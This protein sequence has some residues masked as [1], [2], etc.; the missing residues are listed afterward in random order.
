LFNVSAPRYLSSLA[1]VLPAERAERGERLQRVA[2]TA[3]VVHARTYVVV[4]AF[5]GALFL[6]VGVPM[7]VLGIIVVSWGLA[8]VLHAMA[9]FART[10]QD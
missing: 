8:L 7:F 10:S 6:L 3:F 2:R 4:N 1:F 5:L 9:T